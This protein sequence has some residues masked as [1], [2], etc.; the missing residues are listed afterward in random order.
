MI[1]FAFSKELRK[2]S[3]VAMWSMEKIRMFSLVVVIIVIQTVRA[4]L[5]Q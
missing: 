2:T 1:R 5:R 3:L 4:N